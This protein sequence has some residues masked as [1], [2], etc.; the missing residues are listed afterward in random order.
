MKNQIIIFVSI[1]IAISVAGV[2]IFIQS[3]SI[4]NQSASQVEEDEQISQLLKNVEEGKIAS[5]KAG[6]DMYKEREWITSGPFQID[7]SLY[8]LGEKIFINVEKLPPGY[9]GKMVFAKIHNST[10]SQV[11]KSLMFDSEKEQQNSYFA[12]FPSLSRQFCT[13]DDIV[14]D[15]EV[16]FEGTNLKTLEFKMINSFVPGNEEY[17]DPVC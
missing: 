16:T 5:E 9:Y 10:H 12:V 7:R 3:E 4:E 15:W 13:I 1:I 14:G 2:F 11:Y 6:F 8:H 17:F